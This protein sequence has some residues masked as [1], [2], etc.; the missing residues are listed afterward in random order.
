MS[1]TSCSQGM[2]IVI[3]LQN[4]L[5]VLYLYSNSFFTRGVTENLD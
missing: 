3:A 5:A 1:E 4:N 2:L